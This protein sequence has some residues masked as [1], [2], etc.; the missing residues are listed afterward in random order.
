MRIVALVVLVTALVT[1][2]ASAQG[3]RR[4][5]TPD[6]RREMIKNRIR[7]LRAQTLTDEL[8]LDDKTLGKVLPI[9]SKWDDVTDKLLRE[10]LDIQRRLAGADAIKDPKAVD[11]LIDDAVANQKSFWD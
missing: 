7:G 6:E 2:T 3:P 11:K 9:L 1:G 5:L 4:D 10:R 8:K